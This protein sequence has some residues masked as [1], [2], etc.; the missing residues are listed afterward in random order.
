MPLPCISSHPNG[1][2]WAGS[3]ENYL[4]VIRLERTEQG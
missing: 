3:V 4:V 2:A 1:L